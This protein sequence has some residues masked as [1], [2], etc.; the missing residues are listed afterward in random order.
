MGH[1]FNS[2]DEKNQDRWRNYR[3]KSRSFPSTTGSMLHSEGADRVRTLLRYPWNSG[4]G[5]GDECRS[6][7]CRIEG[8]SSLH[9]LDEGRRRNRREAPF[10]ASIFLS[11]VGLSPFL[12]YSYG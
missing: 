10:E 3:S 2:G 5:V 7:G 12:D 6:M 11:R 9:D 4:R 1:Q 8:C